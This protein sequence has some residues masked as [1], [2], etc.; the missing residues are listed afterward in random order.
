MNKLILLLVVA[1]ALWWVAL[2][3]LALAAPGN[4]AATLNFLR[5]DHVFAQAV[6]TKIP[7][8]QTSA[9]SF[10]TE[11]AAECPHILG[12][13]PHT[14]GFGQLASEA[15]LAILDVFDRPLVQAGVVFAER[16]E[17]LRWSS[18][19]LTRLVHV[20][21]AEERAEARVAP[22]HLCADLNAWKASDYRTVP[23]GTE[24]FVRTYL[25]AR[26]GPEASDEAILGKLTPY[27]RPS[28][29]VL[30]RAV[31]HLEAQSAPL[32]RE[33]IAGPIARLSE[34]LDVSPSEL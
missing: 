28:M 11:V 20:H 21:A 29:R 10:V 26:E 4:S 23:Q 8:A 16:V 1:V 2:P 34:A 18:R 22:P 17:R 24:T 19:P 25:A 13:A 9:N 32:L 30:A 15:S 27:E 33:A 31:K 3:C 12:D 14:A 6:R 5:A 7:A